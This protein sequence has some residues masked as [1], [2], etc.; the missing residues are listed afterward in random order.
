MAVYN[1]NQDM[2]TVEERGMDTMEWY[3]SGLCCRTQFS[4]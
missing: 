1:L 2:N 4:N 3:V